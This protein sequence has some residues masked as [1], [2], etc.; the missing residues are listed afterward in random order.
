ML[1]LQLAKV[2]VRMGLYPLDCWARL[3]QAGLLRLYGKLR[4]PGDRKGGPQHRC[5][6]SAAANA[7]WGAG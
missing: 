7:G 1:Q 5:F 2:V 3:V 4:Q 6:Y